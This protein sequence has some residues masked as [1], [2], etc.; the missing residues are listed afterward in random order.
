MEKLNFTSF[1][2]YYG[3]YELKESL[4]SKIKENDFIVGFA[5]SDYGGDFFDRVA[6][7]YFE[8]NYPDNTIS[9]NTC[10]YGKNCFIFGEVAR[11]F[12]EKS[13]NYLL[14]FNDIED[15][16]S[17]KEHEATYESFEYFL[18]DI[19]E[20]Y[21]FKFES[22]IDYLMQEKSGYYSLL[23]NGSLD[24]CY[25]NLIK[26]LLKEK[27]IFTPEENLLYYFMEL[28][29]YEKG[30]AEYLNLQYENNTIHSLNLNEKTL[31]IIK[32]YENTL[33]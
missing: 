28:N 21:I 14:G 2:K 25:D 29:N 6:I 15:F 5:Y 9:E 7:A 17:Q 20:D 23:S 8:E 26:E 18:N 10:Y 19:K 30:I 3:S 27:I 16:Y 4:K 33:K 31:S 13:E 12:Y 11:G 1:E 24:F 22:A 32:D